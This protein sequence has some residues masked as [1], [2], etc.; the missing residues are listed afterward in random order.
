[1]PR[2]FS[3]QTMK[4]CIENK[5]EITLDM[6]DAAGIRYDEGKHFAL[7]AEDII[8]HVTGG[9]NSVAVLHKVCKRIAQGDRSPRTTC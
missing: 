8:Q 9:C 4:K 1:M 2:Y 7:S 6:L 5:Q 3:L